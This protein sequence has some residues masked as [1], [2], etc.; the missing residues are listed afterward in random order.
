MEESLPE[1]DS[2]SPSSDESESTAMR[3][4]FLPV[5]WG[6]AGFDCAGGA[7]CFGGLEL[8]P[9]FFLTLM[10]LAGGSLTEVVVVVPAE[11]FFLA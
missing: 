6:E 11:G 3:F 4:R 8:G 5:A 9:G 1:P 7:C 10:K 2:S